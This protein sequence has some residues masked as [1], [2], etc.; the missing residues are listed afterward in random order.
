M[1]ADLLR[2]D[3]DLAVVV[4]PGLAQQRVEGLRGSV[5]DGLEA[6][7]A[8][9]HHIGESS[10]PLYLMQLSGSWLAVSSRYEFLCSSLSRIIIDTGSLTCTGSENVDTSLPIASFRICQTWIL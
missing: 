8:E 6:G 9:G 10:Y 7:H 4:L 2:D 5:D 1:V 3:P